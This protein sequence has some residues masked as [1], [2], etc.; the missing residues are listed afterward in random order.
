MADLPE[1]DGGES[2]DR[3]T[4]QPKEYQ[5]DSGK[6]QQDVTDDDAPMIDG[7]FPDLS[8]ASTRYLTQE[9]LKEREESAKLR[10][11]LACAA[12]LHNKVEARIIILEETVALLDEK[13]MVLGDLVSTGEQRNTLLERITADAKA[14]LARFQEI[15]ETSTVDQP[16]PTSSRASNGSE[17]GNSAG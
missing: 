10:W 9:V 16:A 5:E 3:R 12:R 14:D 2:V 13:A 15:S 17:K 4:A 11:Q 1:P 7:V 6:E 8:T